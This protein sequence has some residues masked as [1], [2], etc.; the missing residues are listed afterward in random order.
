MCKLDDVWECYLNSKIFTESNLKDKINLYERKIEPY[1]KYKKIENLTDIDIVVFTKFLMD[2]GLSP[3][4]VKHYLLVFRSILKSAIRMKIY[5]SELPH[6]EFPKI[7]NTRTRYLLVSEAKILLSA[8]EN[9]NIL[10]HD[11]ASFALQTG[12]RAGEIFELQPNAVKI[13]QQ[14]L[15]IYKSKNHTSRIIPLNNT[16]LNIAKKYLDLNLTFL[17]SKNKINHVSSIFTNTIKELGFNDNVVKLDRVSFHTLRHTFASWLVQ[18]GEPLA[19]VSQLLGHNNIQTTMRYAHLAPE[20]AR[21]A[22]DKIHHI[23]QYG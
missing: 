7:N 9:K 8:L 17:F 16:A 19:I 22:V 6:F 5:R 1:W 21:L 12:M 15:I 2:A 4:S 18:N 10:W 14:M 11:I 13:N 3:Q 20:K 23:A